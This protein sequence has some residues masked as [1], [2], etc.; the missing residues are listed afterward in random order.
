MTKEEIIKQMRPV[1]P[2]EVTDEQL[3]ERW[4]QRKSQETAIEGLEIIYGNVEQSQIPEG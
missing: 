3:L 1:Y 4:E 2:K